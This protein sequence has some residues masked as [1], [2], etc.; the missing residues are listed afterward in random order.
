MLE[1]LQEASKK[2]GIFQKAPLLVCYLHATRHEYRLTCFL[3][4]LAR[5]ARILNM[6]CQTLL[7]HFFADTSRVQTLGQF[8]NHVWVSDSPPTV[9]LV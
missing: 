1:D 3:V 2:D 4:L 9:A 7:Q 8:V 5:I 6:P